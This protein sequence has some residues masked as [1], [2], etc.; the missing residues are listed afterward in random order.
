MKA[1]RLERMVI[2]Q[3]RWVNLYVDRVRFPDGHIIEAHHLLDFERPSVVA[4]VMDEVGQ[5]LF[6]EVY[7]YTTSST[8]WEL[9][10]GGIEPGETV[11]EAA[12]REVLEETGYETSA[13]E[14]IYTYYP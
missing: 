2:Y 8:S 14:L 4:H 12:R 11:I 6:V 7:R 5:I 13:P 1:E 3:S 9:P 10:A